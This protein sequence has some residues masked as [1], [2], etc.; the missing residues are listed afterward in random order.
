LATFLATDRTILSLGGFFE[1]FESASRTN[2]SAFTTADGLSF[3]LFRIRFSFADVTPCTVNHQISEVRK[4]Y[5][6]LSFFSLRKWRRSLFTSAISRSIS[7][8]SGANA[9]PPNFVKETDT[10]TSGYRDRFGT[11]ECWE[12]D[13]HSGEIGDSDLIAEAA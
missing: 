5:F 12:L 10:R 9:P 11:D 1:V 6:C 2:A 4:Q 7:T 3:F 13:A 8:K